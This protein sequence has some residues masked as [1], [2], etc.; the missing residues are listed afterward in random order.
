MN[1]NNAA[2]EKL[3]VL[4]PLA[5]LDDK[6]E[7]GEHLLPKCL[8]EVNGKTIIERVVENISNL[9]MSLNFIF[10]LNIDHCETHF[11]HKSIQMLFSKYS[12]CGV[13]YEILKISNQTR[14]ALCSSLMAIDRI[15]ENE[16]LIICNG[17]QIFLNRF[18]EYLDQLFQPDLGAGC[19]THKSVHPRWSYVRHQKGTVLEVSEKNPISDDAICGIYYFARSGTFLDSAKNYILK[20]YNSNENYYISN[21][22]N[23]IILAGIH[24]KCVNVCTDDYVR[25]YSFSRIREFERQSKIG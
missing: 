20:Y 9:D 21:V 12:K 17:D 5:G 7:D 1:K 2:K 3:N 25:F 8:Q 14:G 13:E 18:S 24:V 10:I 16:K 22:F 4:I 19:L 11:L 15:P 23:E 6:L